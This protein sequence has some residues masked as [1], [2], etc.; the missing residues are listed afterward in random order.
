MGGSHWT[1]GE[2]MKADNKIDDLIVANRFK[3]RKG[4]ETADHK[5][6]QRVSDANRAVYERAEERMQKAEVVR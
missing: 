3:P 2:R 6:I 4:M 5:I 1:M